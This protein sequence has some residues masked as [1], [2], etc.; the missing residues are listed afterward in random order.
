[1]NDFNTKIE[2]I[3]A[4][5]TALIA[6]IGINPISKEY[7][8]LQVVL[9]KF[10][11]NCLN[12]GCFYALREK[13]ERKGVAIENYTEETF[14]NLEVEKLK[15]LQQ[16]NKIVETSTNEFIKILKDLDKLYWLALNAGVYYGRLKRN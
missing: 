11:K 7:D 5:E 15:I 12:F 13:Y 6:S 4:F 10:V 2:D 1:M 16:F 14:Q 9:D 3:K 8:N